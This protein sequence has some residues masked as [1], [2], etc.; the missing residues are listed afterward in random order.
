MGIVMPKVPV[1]A[2]MSDR[3]STRLEDV[4]M[5]AAS[6]WIVVAVHLDGRAHFLQLPDSFFTWWH[7]L[8]YSGLAAAALVLL[9]MGVR[10]RGRGQSLV[11]AGLRPPRGYEASLVGAALFFA[12]GVADLV[13]HSLFGVE[14]GLDALLSPAHL[15]LMGGAVLLFTAPCLPRW[16][17]RPDRSGGA[18]RRW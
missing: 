13:W 3:D 1:D 11:A 2:R 10:R 9:A 14:F 5:A 12:G 6:V 17:N 15:M 4:G 18:W 16:P 7:L 8:M